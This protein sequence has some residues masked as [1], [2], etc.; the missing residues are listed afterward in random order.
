MFSLIFWLYI[1][2]GALSFIGVLIGFFSTIR[3]ACRY[4]KALRRRGEIQ[5]DYR[6]RLKAGGLEA[7]RAQAWQS[8]QME[9]EIGGGR[10]INQVLNAPFLGGGQTPES[11]AYR[12]SR[13]R[14]LDLAFVGT[15]TV[16]VSVASVW[17]LSLP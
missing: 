13:S 1:I 8:R 3:P 16:L 6:A 7:S 5:E 4:K 12:E 9:A 2:G 15:G 14:G 10:T 17:S 11:L